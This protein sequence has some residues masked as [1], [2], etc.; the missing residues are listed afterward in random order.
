MISRVSLDYNILVLTLVFCFITLLSP[1]SSFTKRLRF[2]SVITLSSVNMNSWLVIS[3]FYSLFG[4]FL[5]FSLYSITFSV[6][7]TTLGR[8]SKNRF[9]SHPPL[10]FS[11]FILGNISSLPPFLMFLGKVY[12][13]KILVLAGSG[14]LILLILSF[15]RVFVTYYYLWSIFFFIMRLKPAFYSGGRYFIKGVFPSCIALVMLWG[16]M[17]GLII[18]F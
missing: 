6:T 17:V 8:V 1:L 10:F 18:I 12:I 7:A 15:S 14:W 9:R 2:K 11:L 5:F 16:F 4:F 3:S 13:F